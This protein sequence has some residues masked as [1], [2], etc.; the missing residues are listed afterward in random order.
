MNDANDADEA[1]VMT[2]FT[3]AAL[4]VIRAAA[5]NGENEETSRLWLAVGSALAIVLNINVILID[6]ARDQKQ[7]EF[8]CGLRELLVAHPVPW[9]QVCLT[10]RA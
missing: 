10:R 5:L 2:E 6:R 7:V 8:L 4:N 1:E 9:T 3:I